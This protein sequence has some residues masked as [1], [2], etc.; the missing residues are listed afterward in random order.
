MSATAKV[1]SLAVAPN[2]EQKP[3]FSVDLTPLIGVTNNTSGNTIKVYLGKFPTTSVA[4]VNLRVEAAD[5]SVQ[6]TLA[7][8]INADLT[9]ATYTSTNTDAWLASAKAFNI[10][11]QVQLTGDVSGPGGTAVNWLSS[12]V[13]INVV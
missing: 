5:G 13:L 4:A 1:L 12:N 2:N 10:H 8:T 11:A 6:E 3:E 7:T 9:S